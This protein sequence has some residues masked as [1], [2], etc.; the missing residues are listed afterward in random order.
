MKQRSAALFCAVNSPAATIDLSLVCSSGSPPCTPAWTPCVWLRGLHRITPLDR[1]A[2]W[3]L[4]PGRALN[5]LADAS[6]FVPRGV[7]SRGRYR[8]SIRYSCRWAGARNFWTGNWQWGGWGLG[9]SALRRSTGNRVGLVV[10]PRKLAATVQSVLTWASIVASFFFRFWPWKHYCS[11][12]L[13]RFWPPVWISIDRWIHI[14]RRLIANWR[15]HKSPLEHT[16]YSEDCRSV[17]L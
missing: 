7:V 1:T 17:D 8:R 6:S 5:S 14:S 3:S 9:R 16:L 10:S 2:A 12:L 13:L 11:C 15:Y 4:L